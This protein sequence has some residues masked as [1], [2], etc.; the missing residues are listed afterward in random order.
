MASQALLN[1]RSRAYVLARAAK[2]TILR[3]VPTYRNRRSTE[4]LRAGVAV[5]KRGSTD[6]LHA[7]GN[8]L[9]VER[10]GE[11]IH[12][13]S[14]T[15]L[16]GLRGVSSGHEKTSPPTFGKRPAAVMV[17]VNVTN[18]FECGCGW[19]TRSLMI[20][21]CHNEKD[22][23][24]ELSR[25]RAKNWF[26]IKETMA[27]SSTGRGYVLVC[28]LFLLFLLTTSSSVHPPPFSLHTPISYS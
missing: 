8:A 11:S 12:S 13:V 6:A 14:G 16:A 3:Y 26:D 24:L 21:R 28:P 18:N 9:A 15:H 1:L 25:R 2:V 27:I 10:L 19:A 4:R 23:K 22:I 20:R 17:E 7:R 5:A